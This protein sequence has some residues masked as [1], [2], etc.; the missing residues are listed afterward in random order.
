MGAV[1]LHVED[2]LIELLQLGLGE[3][4]GQLF[5]ADG[6]EMN[7]ATEGMNSLS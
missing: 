7:L 6:L 3:L 1:S 2:S 5:E 4:F